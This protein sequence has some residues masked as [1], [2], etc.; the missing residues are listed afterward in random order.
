MFPH[1]SKPRTSGVTAQD[2]REVLLPVVDFA[3]KSKRST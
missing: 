2:D 1:M 3:C